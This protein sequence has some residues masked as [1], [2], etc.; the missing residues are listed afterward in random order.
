[1]RIR[2]SDTVVDGLVVVAVV[3]CVDVELVSALAVD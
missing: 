1:M 3:D 2:A